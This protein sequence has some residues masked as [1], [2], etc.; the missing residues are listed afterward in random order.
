MFLKSVGSLLVCLLLASKAYA[1]VLDPDG[2]SFINVAVRND[3]RPILSYWAAGEIRVY[4][5]SDVACSDGVVRTIADSAEVQHGLIVRGN[6]RPLIS[7]TS[8]A[9]VAVAF[10]CSDANCSSGIA[11]DTGLSPSG[12]AAT[13]VLGVDGNPFLVYASIPGITYFQCSTPACDAGDDATVD[14][15]DFSTLD[16]GHLSRCSQR[17][18]HS[19]VCAFGNR[20]NVS[21]EHRLPRDLRY[22]LQ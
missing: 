19:H 16:A 22:E 8:S 18:G 13:A 9:D 10:D 5:C 15:P 11:L 4:D 3:G 14:F 7:Y 17:F 2:G 21:V 6:G 12:L 1:R 20:H